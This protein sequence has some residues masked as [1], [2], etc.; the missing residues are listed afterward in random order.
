MNTPHALPDTMTAAVQHAYGNADVLSPATVPTPSP[1]P[2]QVL[3]RIEAS[4]LNP[5]DVFTMTGTPFVLRLMGGV[6]RPRQPIRGSDAAGEIVA[7]GANV[8]EWSVGDRVFGEAL[9]SL[10]EY[11]V[12]S[13]DRIAHLPSSVSARAGAATV[14]A[15]LAALHGLRTAGLDPLPEGQPGGGLE[16]KRILVI[17]AGGGIGSFAVQLA[18]VAGAHV[19][20]V[21]SS[22]AADAVTQC[23]AHVT[24]DYAKED[25]LALDGGFDLIFDN[26]GAHAMLDMEPL[27]AP[28]GLLLP[29]S[30]IH[31]ADGGALARVAKANWHEK[32]RRRRIGSFYSSPNRADLELLAGLLAQG[33][34]TPLVDSVWNLTDAAAAMERV[35]DGHAH[36]KVVVTPNAP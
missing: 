36:G 34:L 8:T 27:T 30:G 25:V 7:V 13:A 20:G 16:G 15:A 23:G 35:A 1:K 29:N 3:I 33:A 24:V 28:D 22:T 19:T 17:G 6:S 5:A 14:M 10:A 26:V 9:G 11:A 18:S 12:A 4:A 21:C 32:I 31:G 2:R